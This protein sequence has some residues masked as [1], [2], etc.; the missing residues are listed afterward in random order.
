MI[1]EIKSIINVKKISIEEKPLFKCFCG[2]LSENGS[3]ASGL[4]RYLRLCAPTL[5]VIL[6]ILDP[7]PITPTVTPK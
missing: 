6:D 2:A 4:P 7:P 1:F 5:S 3:I